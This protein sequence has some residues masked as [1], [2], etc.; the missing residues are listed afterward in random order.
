MKVLYK[1]AIVLILL[2]A[3]IPIS[4]FAAPE[5]AA[6]CSITYFEDGSYLVVELITMDIRSDSTKTSTKNYTY[7][8][9]DNT[10]QWR[11]TLSATFTYNGTSA[12]CTV[13]VCTV[14]IT[15]GNWYTISKSSS[16]SGNTAYGYLTMGRKFAGVTVEEKSVTMKMACSPTGVI[17]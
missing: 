14:S 3:L 2:F 12:T 17:S 16:K 11:G 10:V 5:E 13:S 4:V 8:E 15:N 1:R 6:E 7:Y 9:G